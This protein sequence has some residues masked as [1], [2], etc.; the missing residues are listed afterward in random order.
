MAENRL[1]V[2]PPAFITH[3]PQRALFLCVHNAARSQMAEGFAHHFAPEGV[4]VWSAGSQPCE[5]N[6]LAIEVMREVGIDI[7]RQHSKHIDDV[8]WRD[9]DTVITL[10]GEADEACP[11]VAAEVRRRH[12]FLPDPAMAPEAERLAAFR[13][14]RDEIRWRV[15]S[16]WP[17]GE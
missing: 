4:E 16:L 2:H 13:E 12:W 14:A 10:C 7:T 17:G 15:A 1:P 6:P 11:A 8:P 3:P 9:A 5:V